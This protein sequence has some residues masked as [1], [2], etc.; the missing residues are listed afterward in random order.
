VWHPRG[1]GT[2]VRCSEDK[3]DIALIESKIEEALKV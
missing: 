2:F 1:K 3:V